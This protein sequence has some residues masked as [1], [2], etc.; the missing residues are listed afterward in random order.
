M[1]T[2]SQLSYQAQHFSVISKFK[3]NKEIVC[4]SKSTFRKLGN[5]NEA[6]NGNKS[7][8]STGKIARG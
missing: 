5:V 8:Q 7:Y 6:Y 4:I 3:A 2:I 1:K